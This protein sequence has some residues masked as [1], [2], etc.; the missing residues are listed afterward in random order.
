MDLRDATRVG[1]KGAAWTVWNIILPF[2]AIK[3]TG[4]L[5]KR[6]V[7]RNK[8]N[9]LYLKEL[10]AEAKKA[11]L[12]GAAKSANV[13]QSFA[14]AMANRSDDALPLESLQRSF[15]LKKRW[16]LVS[17]V[18][19]AFVAGF[20]G[21]GGVVTGSGRTVALC[22]ASLTVSQPL[23]F[24]AAL[25][26][27]LRLWQLRTQRLSA[28]EKGALKDFIAEY[29]NWLSQV[30]SPEISLGRMWRRSAAKPGSTASS[31]EREDR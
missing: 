10:S 1:K 22:I 15:L 9:V 18:L 30:L 7:E 28:A 14:D 6:E 20:A 2:S 11:L 13:D 31:A 21:I 24:L 16:A 4:A 12:E 29:P 5:A 23:F 19:F 27:Q 8:E 25:G 3:R 26:A 17:A